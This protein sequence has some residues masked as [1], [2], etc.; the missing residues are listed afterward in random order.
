[1]TMVKALAA[2]ML[3]VLTW[4]SPG[5]AELITSHLD[6][7]A[8]LIALL[9]ADNIAFVAE[10]R[11]GDLGGAATFELDLGQSTAAPSVTAQ[12]G[13]QSG[14]V[15]PFTLNYD[16]NLNTVEFTLGGNTLVYIPDRA[17]TEVFVRTR[18]VYEGTAVTVSD[19][20][21]DGEPVMD[22]STATGAGGLDILRIEGAILWDSFTLTGNAVLSWT[23]TPPH[24]SNLAFQIKVG[25]PDSSTATEPST[26]GLVKRL[27]R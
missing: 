12:Y 19:M 26:W 10:G 18:A 25:T 17:F 24:Q 22:L 6:N 20:V 23:G 5:A 4:V 9:P 14:V 1:M 3:V 2:L 15:E 13:W 7:D 21:L 11:I 16:N 27:Y 8:D